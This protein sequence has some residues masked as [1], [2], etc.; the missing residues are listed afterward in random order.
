[1]SFL[2]RLNHIEFKTGPRSGSGLLLDSHNASRYGWDGRTGLRDT[3]DNALLRYHPLSLVGHILILNFEFDFFMDVDF[4]SECFC[5][6]SILSLEKTTLVVFL[7]REMREVGN[8][9][10]FISLIS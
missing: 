5:C 4:T 8:Y 3:D 10:T 7:S 1:M 9:L 6:F 2:I